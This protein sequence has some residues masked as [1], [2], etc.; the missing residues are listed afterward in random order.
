MRIS[1]WSSDVCSSDLLDTTVP[2]GDVML[3]AA[4]ILERDG[5]DTATVELLRG[6][7]GGGGA[8][9]ELGQL[10]DIRLGDLVGVLPGEE[11]SALGADVNVLDLLTTS[12]F[13]SQCTDPEDLSTCSAV[14]VPGVDL[15][16]PLVNAA[17][18]VRV[19]QGKVSAR[20]PVGTAART[21]QAQDDVSL[22]TGPDRQSGGRGKRGAE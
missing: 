16:L 1:D 20:G 6:L 11:S 17:S 15:G 3:A 2:I 10:P 22:Q 19:I 12:A 4:S 21:N 9:A 14:S 18:A 8:T 13:A 7:F 5:G